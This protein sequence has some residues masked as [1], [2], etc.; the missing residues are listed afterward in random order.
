[1]AMCDEKRPRI[2]AIICECG[3]VCI[4]QRSAERVT[5]YQCRDC[6]KTMKVARP[7][8]ENRKQ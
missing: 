6:S 7:L 4:A 8:I 1:M 3:G 5:Y 2:G